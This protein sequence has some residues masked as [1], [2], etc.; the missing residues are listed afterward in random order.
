M[1]TG[2]QDNLAI[3]ITEGLKEG[4]EVING[5]YNA[6]SKLLKNGMEVKKSDKGEMVS[7]LKKE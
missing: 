2:I 5:P 1:K 4:D 3:E 6:V 7:Q